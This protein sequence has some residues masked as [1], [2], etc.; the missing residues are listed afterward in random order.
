M[1][2]GSWSAPASRSR[3]GWAWPSVA[4]ILGSRLA[5]RRC[6]T[7]RR[8]RRA[9][10]GRLVGRR[11]PRIRRAMLRRRQP[12]T[13]AG[14]VLM[15]E[16]GRWQVVSGE[17]T[18]L[19][20]APAAGIV[21]EVV[22]GRGI[23]ISLAG[24]GVPGA[25]A[26]G[27]PTRGRLELV[28][29]EAGLRGSLDVGRAGSILVVGGRLDSETISRARAMGVRGIVVPGLAGKDLRDLV[30][31]EAR[32]R[33][34]LQALAPFA[35]LVLDGTFRRPIPTPLLTLFER[36][37]GREVGIVP[38]RPCS[39][40]TRRSTVPASRPIGSGSATVSWPVARAAGADRRGISPVP[41]R[42]AARGGHGR[43][44]RR[45]DRDRADPRPRA[46]QL[47]DGPAGSRF[48]Y[49]R[50][51][52]ATRSGVARA[53]GPLGLARGDPRPRRRPRLGRPSRRPDRASRRARGRQDPVRQGLRS[54]PGRDGHD[55]LAELRPDGRVRRPPAALP[56]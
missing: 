4:G 54:G 19:L 16:A 13:A 10:P 1:A 39:S 53:S 40:S 44:R 35:V 28:T 6:P 46:L 22:P 32:Q 21:R 30:A 34:S 17:H 23:G 49:P 50:P 18:E 48:G 42:G 31:S 27:G 24:Y 56:P 7:R 11:R 52:P 37:D 20:E 47:T 3:P 29:G 43:A 15:S 26:A 38:I 33:A 2:T 55:Q 8:R 5:R 14:E 51:M 41:G 45:R 25:F 12:R 9:G 36:L